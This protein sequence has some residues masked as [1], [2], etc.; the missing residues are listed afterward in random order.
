MDAKTLSTVMGGSLPLSRYEQLQ[1]AF[2]EA[3]TRAGCT[4]A[5]RSAMFCA[6]I[7]HESVGLRY[8]EEIADGSA[9]NGRA[10][11]GNVRPGDGPRYKGRGP[12][13]ITGRANYRSLSAWGFANG[14]CPTATYFEDYPEKLSETGYGFLGAVWY[15][16]AARPMN[17]Y[18]DNR[19][20]YGATRAVNGGLN[21]IE[22]RKTRYHR[23]LSLGDKLLPGDEL[24]AAKDDI[25][26]FIKS[27]VGPIGS[28]VKDIREQ[29]VGGRDLVRRPDGSVDL[30]KSFPGWKIL[31]QRKD[32]SNRTLVDAIGVLVANQEDLI[33][34]IEQL[35]KR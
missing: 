4:T 16:T 21:G 22:D 13:Q 1:P 29:M 12:I 35:E 27:Y 15:W 3:L 26:A 2:N 7:G 33:K 10:D 32:G 17:S 25:I 23:A 31:G 34:R 8:M 19:D 6:Q 18:A 30:A 9:Y 14:Y 24:L 20:I 28:D 11:L 5:D